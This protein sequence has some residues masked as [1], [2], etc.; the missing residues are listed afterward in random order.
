MTARFNNRWFE[1]WLEQI[2][3]CCHVANTMAK[4]ADPELWLDPTAWTDY[5]LNPYRERSN[6]LEFHGKRRSKSPRRT[7][8]SAHE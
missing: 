4:T 5:W 6:P 1:A 2:A 7:Q 8:S 3:V